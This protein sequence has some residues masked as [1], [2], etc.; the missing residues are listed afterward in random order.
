MLQLVLAM[1]LVAQPTPGAGVGHVVD[2]RDRTQGV[3]PVTDKWII[4]PKVP[5]CKTDAQIQQALAEKADGIIPQS[6]DPPR[7][8][9][10]RH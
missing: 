2:M 4:P 5:D 8:A 1:L 3:T 10:Q 7:S 6:C 9:Y